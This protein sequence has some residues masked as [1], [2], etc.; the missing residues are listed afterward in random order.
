MFQTQDVAQVSSGWKDRWQ[1]NEEKAERTVVGVVGDDQD[2][3]DVVGYTREL[4]KVTKVGFSSV[5]GEQNIQRKF[6]SFIFV[7]F[8]AAILLVFDGYAPE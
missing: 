7:L 4:Q 5:E 3:I 8:K 1:E 2:N 6:A